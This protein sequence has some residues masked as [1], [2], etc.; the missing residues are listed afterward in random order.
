[1]RILAFVCVR[2]GGPRLWCVC[3]VWF[4]VVGSGG[5][6]ARGRPWGGRGCCLW[7]PVRAARGVLNGHGLC[8]GVFMDRLYLYLC[9][10]VIKNKIINTIFIYIYVYIY[11]Y[12]C[13]QIRF[14]DPRLEAI[15]AQGHV[16]L[17]CEC[18]RYGMFA[19]MWYC[20]VLN[21]SRPYHWGRLCAIRAFA[22][23]CHSQRRC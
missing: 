3:I 8:S 18:F 13:I 23:S 5:L 12:M 10:Y 15:L 2:L 6:C 19:P 7:C 14:F 11:I 20:S 9:I 1:M 17:P 21:A 4:P 16:W 22:R